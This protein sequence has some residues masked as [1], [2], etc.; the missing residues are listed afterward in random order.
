MID[1]PRGEK[2]GV[3]VL[4]TLTKRGKLVGEPQVS[5][6]DNP[7]LQPFVI[8]AIKNAS[9]FPPFP[10]SLQKEQQAFKINLNYE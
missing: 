1:R 10:G 7:V 8:R 4:F 6:I 5:S 3:E 2:G 9:P